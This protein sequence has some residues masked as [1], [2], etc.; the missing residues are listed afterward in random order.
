MTFVYAYVSF[1]ID[2]NIFFKSQIR[3]GLTHYK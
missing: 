2:F 1:G 3:G